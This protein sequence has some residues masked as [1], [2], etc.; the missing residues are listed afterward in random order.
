M[1][2]LQKF[3]ILCSGA[4]LGVLQKTPTE[5]NKF[6]GIGGI[7][8]TVSMPTSEAKPARG[9][10]QFGDAGHELERRAVR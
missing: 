7:I 2:V 10:K 4:N 1:N 6:A 8:F 9:Y 5:W 3:L